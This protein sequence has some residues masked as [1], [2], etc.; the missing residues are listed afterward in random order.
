MA[1]DIFLK[2]DDV[3]G[4]SAVKGHEASMEILSWSWGMTQSGSSHTGGGG[5]SGKVSVKDL[6]F[7]KYVDSGTPNLI[8]FCCNGKHFKEAKLTVRKAGASPVEYL[9]I[10]MQQVLVSSVTT[11]VTDDTN[12]RIKETVSLNFAKFEVEYKPQTGT[13]S[14]GGGIPVTWNIAANAEK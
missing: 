3:K 5:G 6:S 11:G 13:G 2:I 1:V 14:P 8:K 9:I 10:K 7:T 4:E 12:D